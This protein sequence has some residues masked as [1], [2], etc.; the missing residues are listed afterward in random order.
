MANGWYCDRRQCQYGR[1]FLG[2]IIIRLYH[3]GKHQFKDQILDELDEY[4]ENEGLALRFDAETVACYL[5][6][7]LIVDGLEACEMMRMLGI[8]TQLFWEEIG[9]GECDI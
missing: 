8:F 4:C 5:S 7:R 3:C 9:K 1:F 6:R 2:D